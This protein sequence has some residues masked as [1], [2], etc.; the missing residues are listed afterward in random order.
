MNTLTKVLKRSLFIAA[1]LTGL[2]AFSPLWAQEPSTRIKQL[3]KELHAL[4]QEKKST[5]KKESSTL[6][7]LKTIEKKIGLLSEKLSLQTKQIERTKA[8]LVSLQKQESE[9]EKESKA[10]TLLLENHLISAYQMGRSPIIKTL[11]NEENPQVIERLASYYSYIN[12]ARL[13][14][15][16]NLQKTT[17]ALSNTKKEQQ[18]TLKTLKILKEKE[19]LEQAEL[20]KEQQRQLTLVKDLRNAIKNQTSKISFAQKSKQDL[21]KILQKAIESPYPRP[22]APFSRMQYK[23]SWPTTGYLNDL[24]GKLIAGTS[25]KHSGVEIIAPES[26]IIKAVYPGKIVFADWLR[27][28]GLITIIDHGLGYMTLYAHNQSLLKNQGE[29]VAMGEDIATVG[30]SGGQQ[31]TGV[32]FE[33]RKNGRPVDPLRWLKPERSRA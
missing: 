12:K 20:E 16:L 10:Q 1:L 22:E 13:E 5:K 7:S 2:C 6:A 26:Q 14:A 18:A 15:I 31:E 3:E 32:Y 11:L 29:N 30:H 24:Y 9:L 17:T 4:F 33:I 21:E 27:G 8:E 23:L 28:F 25:L 19:L